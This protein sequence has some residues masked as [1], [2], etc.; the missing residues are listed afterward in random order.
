MM[1]WYADYL[2]ALR[3]GMTEDQR[4]NFKTMVNG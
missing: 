3:D 4:K 2:D 1:Q